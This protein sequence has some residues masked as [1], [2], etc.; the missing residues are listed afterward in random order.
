MPGR[1]SKVAVL[2][3][4][5]VA[6][7]CTNP[8]SPGAHVRVEG[9]M[10][11]AGADTLVV[12]DRL[13]VSDTLRLRVG[14]VVS[15]ASIV[16]VRG[17]EAFIPGA[18]YFLEVAIAPHGVLAF[19][20]EAAGAFT[21]TLRA[22]SGGSAALSIR[23]MHGRLGSRFAHSDFDAAVVPVIVAADGG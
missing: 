18:G 15:P 16:F 6:A 2:L 17:G 19:E 23:L 12:G 8:V 9:F 7:A 14:D 5:F 4:M 1:G 3:L 21:G 20:P 10:V 22:L 13:T 11:M